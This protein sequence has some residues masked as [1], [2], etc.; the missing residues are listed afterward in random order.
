MQACSVNAVAIDEPE[1]ETGHAEQAQ[2]HHQ[3][4]GDGA[5]TECHGQGVIQ[6][7]GSSLCGAHVGFHRDVHA[8]VASQ[9]REDRADGKAQ[10]CG[11]AQTRHEQDDQEQDHPHDGDGAVLAVQVRLGA[12]L[13]G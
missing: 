7:S 3:H 13:D 2:T 8:D 9:A 12:L 6:T 11:P 5:T 1:E 10:G 4:A